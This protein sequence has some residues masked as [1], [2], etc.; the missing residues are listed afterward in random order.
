[1]ASLYRLGISH[2]GSPKTADFLIVLENG[3]T[4]G[5]HLPFMG[6]GF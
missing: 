6:S 2:A 1:M 5:K 3:Q 4:L